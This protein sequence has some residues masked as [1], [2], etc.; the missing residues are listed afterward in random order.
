MKRIVLMGGPGGGKS[1]TLYYLKDVFQK[2]GY[3]TYID[4]ETCTDVLKSGFTIENQG[5]YR[6]QKLIFEIQ[7]AK[8]DAYVKALKNQEDAILFI[9]RCLYDHAGFL[10]H[11][12]FLRLLEGESVELDSIQE[13]YDLILFL[14]TSAKIEKYV[15]LSNPVRMENRQEAL[16]SNAALKKAASYFPNTKFVEAQ[17]TIEIKQEKARQIVDEFLRGEDETSR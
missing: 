2:Q 6:F 14:E 15:Q 13:R 8:E 7:K 4:T 17:D 11:E 5:I 1:E 16:L 10:D 9:D 12:D 3:S